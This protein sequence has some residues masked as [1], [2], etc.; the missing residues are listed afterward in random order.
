MLIIIGVIRYLLC[1]FKFLLAI[2][3]VLAMEMRIFSE[4]TPK[5]YCL[6]EPVLA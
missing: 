1:H 6:K 4:I 3:S 5:I 2:E